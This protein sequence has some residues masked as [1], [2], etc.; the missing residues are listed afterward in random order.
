MTRS[1]N[2]PVFFLPKGKLAKVLL[3]TS[4]GC[5]AVDGYKSYLKNNNQ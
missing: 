3:G 4:L 1:D 2:R 5:F